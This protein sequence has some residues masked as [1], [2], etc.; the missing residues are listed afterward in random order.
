MVYLT[1]NGQTNIENGLPV[2]DLSVQVDS[3]QTSEA[4]LLPDKEGP[5][6]YWQ[7]ALIV[8]SSS[9]K[10]QFSLS[11]REIIKAG[12]G[13]W[14]DWDAG[15]VSENTSASMTPPQAVRVVSS[16]GAVTGEVLVL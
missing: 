7:L 11:P 14:L 16:S 8:N 5:R 6:H 9:G 2:F 1:A 4:I 13:N 10:F 12:G 3:G 15:V